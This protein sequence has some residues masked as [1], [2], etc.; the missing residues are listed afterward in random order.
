MQAADY[1]AAAHEAIP[2]LLGVASVLRED[3]CAVSPS[4]FTH[5]SIDCFTGHR[6]T[7]RFTGLFTGHRFADR[8]ANRLLTVTNLVS[9]CDSA[10]VYANFGDRT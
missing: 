5:R 8:F 4:R 10:A 9:H 6:F 2:T 3:V 7:D 1:R